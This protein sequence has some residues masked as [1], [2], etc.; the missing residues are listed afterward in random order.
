MV[1]LILGNPQIAR[2][3]QNVLKGSEQRNVTGPQD[4]SDRRS[5]IS[6]GVGEELPVNLGQS[7]VSGP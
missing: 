7:P 5:D 4:H 1:P 2:G 6:A 3:R